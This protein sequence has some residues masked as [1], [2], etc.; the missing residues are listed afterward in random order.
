[1]PLASG[2][3]C[4]SSAFRTSVLAVT[5]VLL[6]LPCLA[7]QPRVLAP[8]KPVA[9][10]LPQPK[11]WHKPAAPQ[12]L[13]GGLWMIDSNLKSSVYLKNDLKTSPLSVTPI[14][15]LSNGV[16]YS[17]PV[18]NLDPSGTAIL[19]IN[20]S[21][22]AQ[23]VAPYATLMGYVE[24]DYQWPWPALCATIRNID[25]VHSVIFTYFPQLALPVLVHPHA[26]P[27]VQSVPQPQPDN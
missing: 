8:H 9:P 7:Q 19:D 15:W 16:K 23:G 27:S 26:N 21:L 14:L 6:A 10:R 17:L 11:T 12:S 22:A 20:Q 5:F 1:M 2:V 4:F 25:P 3:P 13:I 18:V 24:F